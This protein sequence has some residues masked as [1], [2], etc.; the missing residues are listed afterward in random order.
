MP[1]KMDGM[2]GL[3]TLAEKIGEMRAAA[4]EQRE[5]SEEL[6]RLGHGD[7]AVPGLLDTIDG[8]VDILARSL[9]DLTREAGAE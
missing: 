9:V 4:A 3:D 2:S 7:L 5:A 1:G 6:V 8:L